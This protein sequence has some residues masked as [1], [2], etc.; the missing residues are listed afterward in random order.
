MRSKPL[1]IAG[2]VMSAALA[3]SACKESTTPA[4]PL[5]D[6][7]VLTR[8]EGA[9]RPLVIGEYTHA[10]GTRQ[11]YTMLYDSLTFGS[12]TRGRRSFMVAVET[13]AADGTPVVGAILTPVS[14][15]ASV[16][17]RGDRVILNYETSSPIRPDTLAFA[18]ANLVKQGPHGVLCTGCE[19]IRRVEYVY[20]PR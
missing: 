15:M 4:A 11:V 13:L 16:T 2:A 17:R 1:A 20:E 18:E 14:H 7:Y 3:L 19:P 6:V 5:G 12:E 10:S 9:G 8:V